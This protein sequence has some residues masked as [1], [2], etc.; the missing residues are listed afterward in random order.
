MAM[1]EAIA[2]TSRDNE[3]GSGMALRPVKVTFTADPF[4]LL[5]RFQELTE[6]RFQVARS[7]PTAPSNALD[8][9]LD[10]PTTKSAQLK[11]AT[12]I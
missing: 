11:L 1:V 4:P 9:L 2:T 10:C 6:A 12:I 8:T 7:T 5:T 3:E